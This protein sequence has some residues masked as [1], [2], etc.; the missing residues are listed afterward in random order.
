MFLQSVIHFVGHVNSYL[1][2]IFDLTN[3][4]EFDEGVFQTYWKVSYESNG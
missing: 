3:T 1:R 2:D 4:L